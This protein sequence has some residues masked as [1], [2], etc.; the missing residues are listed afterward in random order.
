[1]RRTYKNL[2]FYLHRLP[3]ID[4]YFDSNYRPKIYSKI[5]QV[6][7]TK[8]I[9]EENIWEVKKLQDIKFFIKKYLEYCQFSKRLSMKTIKAYRIDLTQFSEYCH[10]KDCWAD[11]NTVNDYLVKLQQQY[12]VRSTKRKIASIKAFFN[13]LEYEEALNHN[14]FSKLRFRLNEPFILPRTI[15]LE[16]IEML[17]CSAYREKSKCKS[18]GKQYRTKCRDIAVLELLFASGI[19]VSELCSL[20][21]DSV[22]LR[23]GTIRIYG[24]GSRERMI[25]IGNMNVLSALQTYYNAF[26]ANIVENGPFFLN[27]LQSQLSEQSVRF[28]INKYVALS[29]ITSHITPHMFRHSFATLLLEEDVDIRYIQQFLGHRSILTTQIYTH[30]TSKKQREIL[31]DR[32]PRNKIVF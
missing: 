22:N 18:G 9:I 19:R 25:Q 26:S 4:Q 8:D 27:R 2:V 17:L 10:T 31:C 29:G 16:T 13:Y 11:R 20:T 28:M 32:H 7:V 3:L 12:K 21:T 14:P 1:M 30:V 24:K 5:Y 15:P 23:D 6:F